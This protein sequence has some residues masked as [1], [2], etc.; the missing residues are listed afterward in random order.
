MNTIDL[1]SRAKVSERDLSRAAGV[2][3]KTIRKVLSNDGRVSL[4]NYNKVRRVLGVMPTDSGQLVTPSDS[5]VE[6]SALVSAGGDWK[7]HF[8]NFVDAFRREKDFA[9]VAA[10]PV[11]TLE[12]KL[13]ALLASMVCVLCDEQG[14]SKPYWARQVYLLKDPWFVS[15]YE[16]LK[17]SALVESHP[18]F[19]RNNIFVLENFLSRA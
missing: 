14:V 8:F 6:V 19:R 13:R 9:M 1:K 15:G 11:K 4:E 16:S 10:P 17:A 5:A 3:R 7:L 18:Y 2:S 12:L